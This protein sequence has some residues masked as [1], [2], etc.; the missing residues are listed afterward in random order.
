MVLSPH[1]TGHQV[2]HGAQV[3][4]A[5][6]RRQVLYASPASAT[7][8]HST[9]PVAVLG[10]LAQAPMH[11]VTVLA[12]PVSLVVRIYVPFQVIHACRLQAL[13]QRQTEEII[14]QQQAHVQMQVVVLVIIVLVVLHYP[15]RT[16]VLQMFVLEHLIKIV[17]IMKII[18]AMLMVITIVTNGDVL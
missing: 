13:A 7:E 1:V 18:I 11:N 6:K 3:T 14:Q 15:K 9:A 5:A 12:D 8:L 4:E 16:V 2:A 17:K 10:L